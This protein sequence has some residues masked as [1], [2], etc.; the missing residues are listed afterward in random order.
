MRIQ[1]I[2]PVPCHICGKETSLAAI[3]PHPDHPD[4]ELHTFR[5]VDCGLI[6]TVSRRREGL[7]RV[8]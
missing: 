4:I 6:K 3:E 7:P 2:V 5:C 8:A 1:N